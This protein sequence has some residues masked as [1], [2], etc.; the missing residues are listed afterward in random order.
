MNDN[1]NHNLTKFQSFKLKSV[2]MA[3]EEDNV[4][5]I[6]NYATKMTPFDTGNTQKSRFAL[7]DM[8]R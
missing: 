3:E 2:T 7:V 8:G 1:Y 5:T 6:D 4:I